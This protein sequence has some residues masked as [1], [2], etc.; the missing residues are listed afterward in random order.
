MTSS[1]A[2]GGGILESGSSEHSAG[3]SASSCRELTAI[4]GYDALTRGAW[5]ST[6]FGIRHCRTV[7]RDSRQDSIVTPAAARVVVWYD[8]GNSR[9]GH[10]AGREARGHEFRCHTTMYIFA[11]GGRGRVMLT[12]ARPNARPRRFPPL[13]VAPGACPGWATYA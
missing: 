8:S 13:A 1:P 10:G 11:R 3:R 4:R 2:G 12:R 6:F 7:T 5:V 9:F